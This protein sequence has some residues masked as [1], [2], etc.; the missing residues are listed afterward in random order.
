MKNFIWNF[1]E[2]IITL[3]ERKLFIRVRILLFP[4]HPQRRPTLSR[5][6]ENNNKTDHSLT[7]TRATLTF[8]FPGPCKNSGKFA[9]K[10]TISTRVGSW[11]KGGT[12]GRSHYPDIARGN[13]IPTAFHIYKRGPS[14]VQRTIFPGWF[15]SSCKPNKKKRKKEKERKGTREIGSYRSNTDITLLR[16]SQAGQLSLS[17]PET[18]CNFFFFVG[19][20]TSSYKPSKKRKK[21]KEEK[22][23]ERSRDSCMKHEYNA[24]V[25]LS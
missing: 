11:S 1:K 9:I 15:T 20:F 3:E 14:F 18:N 13:S 23:H 19:W 21:K 10:E 24:R 7:Y 12:K 22:R 25:C 17:I 2:M 5:K 4:P 16:I 6:K 8:T